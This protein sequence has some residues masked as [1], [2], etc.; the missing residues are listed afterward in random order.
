MRKLD[1]VSSLVQKTGT[2]R[3]G[4]KVGFHP[5]LIM[6]NAHPFAKTSNIS[7]VDNGKK[8]INTNRIVIF[9]KESE[10]G[11]GESTIIQSNSHL[12]TNVT[13]QIRAFPAETSIQADNIAMYPAGELRNWLA[14]KLTMNEV[15]L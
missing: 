12:F 3:C 6:I 1:D 9:Q 5:V 14:W 10:P 13:P 2:V 15:R 4:E 8:G 7:G 11:P